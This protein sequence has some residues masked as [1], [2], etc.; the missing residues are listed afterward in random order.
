MF[1]NLGTL[2]INKRFIKEAVAKISRD[3]SAGKINVEEITEDKLK[4]LE[5]IGVNKSQAHF[6]H[7]FYHRYNRLNK[8]PNT[9]VRSTA[10]RGDYI[11]LLFVLFHLGSLAL[12]IHVL[13]GDPYELISCTI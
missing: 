5:A 1:N 6:C 10:Y 8:T 13:S 3:V 9:P 11:I 2:K 12:K 7:N 4:K